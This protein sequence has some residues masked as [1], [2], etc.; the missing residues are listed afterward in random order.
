MSHRIPYLFRSGDL[1]LCAY[2]GRVGC[3]GRVGCQCVPEQVGT[4]EF[5]TSDD[6]LFV[7][8]WYKRARG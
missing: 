7:V 8:T 4:K 2:D 1:K 3:K 6:G 5:K